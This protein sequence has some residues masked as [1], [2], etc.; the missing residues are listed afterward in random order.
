MGRPLV[1]ELRTVRRSRLTWWLV[2]LTIRWLNWLL[3]NKETVR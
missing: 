3:G 2:G 1:F